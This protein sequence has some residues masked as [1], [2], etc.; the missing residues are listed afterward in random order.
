[1]SIAKWSAQDFVRVFKN[2]DM[3]FTYIVCPESNSNKFVKIFKILVKKRLRFKVYPF[4]SHNL[5][6]VTFSL[7]LRIME[8]CDWDFVQGLCHGG[9]DPILG[10]IYP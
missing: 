6:P 8:G 7:R 9:L 4:S 5:L 3:S 2:Y 1:M 10:G